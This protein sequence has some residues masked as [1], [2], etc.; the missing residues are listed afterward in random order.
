[1]TPRVSRC[2]EPVVAGDAGAALELADAECDTRV[3]D[4]PVLVKQPG[5]HGPDVRPQSMTD[6]LSKPSRAGRVHI[7]VEQY[8]HRATRLRYGAIGAE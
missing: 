7:I 8:Q 3:L 1:M 5:A 2:T 6:Q 4:G